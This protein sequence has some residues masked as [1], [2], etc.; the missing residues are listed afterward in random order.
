MGAATCGVG[1]GGAQRNACGGAAITVGR[2]DCG[3]CGNGAWAWRCGTTIWG[4]GR[5]PDEAAGDGAAGDWTGDWATRGWPAGER[6]GGDGAA[7]DGATACGMGGR[8]MSGD[9]PRGANAP[10]ATGR[11]IGTGIGAV[12]SAR[13]LTTG[14][15]ACGRGIATIGPGAR[16]GPRPAG[17]D[18]PA[19]VWLGREG[20]WASGCAAAMACGDTN[21]V[22]RATGR[23]LIIAEAGT[24][25]VPWRLRYWVLVISGPWPRLIRSA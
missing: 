20:G 7:G 19:L 21:R 10:C 15:G 22:L 2:A 6:A 5:G 9:G 25:V 14:P 24:T 11:A 8:A 17:A 1:V 18:N 3:I 16:P 4:I 12:G 13:G 23:E